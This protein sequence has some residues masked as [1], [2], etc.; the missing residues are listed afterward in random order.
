MYLFQ[1]QVFY[2]RVNSYLIESNKQTKVTY[3]VGNVETVLGDLEPITLLSESCFMWKGKANAMWIRVPR[4]SMLK[5]GK[6][7][8]QNIFLH[9]SHI[10]LLINDI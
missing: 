1:K 7:I 5:I 2:E 4:A 10:Y 9:Q 8:V 3:K 6:D